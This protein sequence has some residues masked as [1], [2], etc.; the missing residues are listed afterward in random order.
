MIDQCTCAWC[1][2]GFGLMVF[3]DV[4]ELRQRATTRL[5][6]SLVHRSTHINLD[7]KTSR[8]HSTGLIE[9]K[10]RGT[11]SQ[12]LMSSFYDRCQQID[13]KQQR[14]ELTRAGGISSHDFLELSP[15]GDRQK[16]ILSVFSVE[17]NWIR[18]HARKECGQSVHVS[19]WYQVA[20]CDRTMRR[21]VTWHT[22]K[23]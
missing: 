7:L 13:T 21:R 8:N 14:T 5:D 6:A 4:S 19:T 2:D 9:L 3:A 22:D 15:I 23:H 1:D 11:Q 17:Q 10:L 16:L 12:F 18:R 20:L